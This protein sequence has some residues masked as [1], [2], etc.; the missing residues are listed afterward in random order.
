MSTNRITGLAS[1]MDYESMI[2]KL[3]QASSAPLNKLEKNQTKVEWQREAMIEINSKFL[4]FRTNALDMKLEGTYK[5]FLA[6]SSNKNLISASANSDAQE[7]TYKVSVSSLA[8]KTTLD[9]M[10]L[11][12][13]ITGSI[14]KNDIPKLKG[15]SFDITYNGQTKTITFDEDFANNDKALKDFLNKEIDNAFGAEQIEVGIQFGLITIK[16]DTTLNMPVTIT[17]PAAEG[18]TDALQ[19][20]NIKSGE[21]TV[22]DSGK[23]LEEVVLDADGNSLFVTTDEITLTVNGKDFKFNKTDTLSE[24]FSALNKDVDTDI[25]IKYSDIKQRMTISRD[26]YGGG[27][28]IEITANNAVDDAFWS[29]LGLD[30]YSGK[31]DDFRD[32]GGSY[33]TG[34]NAVFNIT[35]PDGE[36]A[37]EVQSSSNIFT[38][39]GVSMTF[40]EANKNETVSITVSKNVDEI[41]DK[42][43][44]FTDAYNDLLGTLNKYYK[45]ENT[46]YEPLTDEEREALSDTQQE[47][48]E[49]L[50]KQGILRRDSTL[51]DAINSMRSAVTSFVSNSSISSLFEIGISTSSYDAVNSENNGKL[52]IDE[53]KLKEAIKNDLDGVT[54]L[55][56]SS[57]KQIQGNKLN[58]MNLN[59]DGTSFDI[60]FGGT[61]K[62]ISLSGQY[63]LEDAT[64]RTE[65]EKYMKDILANEFGEGRISVTVSGNKILFNSSK[66]IDMMFNISDAGRTDES[67]N[68]LSLFGVND[69]DKFDSNERGFATKIYDICT[70]T[71][72]S[73]VDKAGA[74][75]TKVDSSTLGQ[76]LD[77]I[78]ES[79]TKQKDRLAMLEERYYA[80]FAAMEKAISEM[81]SQSS[82][83]MNMLSGG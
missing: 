41:Y 38:Y 29:S 55:F 75:A 1:G 14:N 18:A 81:N 35:S 64:S 43:K 80:Q 32:A 77:R 40:L 17:S 16:S 4:S 79:I 2:E 72:N 54:K 22:F 73:L 71:M 6:E 44:G 61:K 20:L 7:G 47:K 63:N 57:P 24:V 26:S 3:I 67:K 36:T 5:S 74:S 15:S 62:T 19:Y 46:G 66:N 42:I 58:N 49:K 37:K 9:G 34:S 25:T 60:T 78:K 10:N 59:L 76:Q 23:T 51:G 50:A 83:I 28:P 45:E 56:A 21:S 65:F 8:T 52:V 12:Q 33:E 53:N 82:S 11:E 39:N 48:W 68:A 27:K 70:T 30:Y 13:K 69:G 31:I